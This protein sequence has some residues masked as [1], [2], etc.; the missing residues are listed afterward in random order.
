MQ[1]QPHE[2][3]L[4]PQMKQEQETSSTLELLTSF[5]HAGFVLIGTAFLLFEI[6]FVTLLANSFW[7]P[8]NLVPLGVPVIVLITAATHFVLRASEE[9]PLVRALSFIWKGRPPV[10]YRRWLK[11]DENGFTFGVKRIRWTVIESAELSFF[12]N[13]VF[14]SR[15]LCGEPCLINGKDHNPAEVILKLPFSAAGLNEQKRFFEALKANRPAVQL[16]SRL[17]KQIEQP[18]LKGIALVQAATVAFLFAALV[19]AGYSTFVYLETL[20]GYYQCL[21]DGRDRKSTALSNFERAEDLRLHPFPIS[22]V[23][24]KLTS[25]GGVSEVLQQARSEALWSLG[26]REES[27]AVAKEIAESSPKAFRSHLRLARLYCLLGKQD[28]AQDELKTAIEKRDEALLPR[29]Y[30]ISLLLERGR[31]HDAL[32]AFEKY[33]SKLDEEVFG[34]RPVWPPGGERFVTDVWYR[35]DLDFVFNNELK[36]AKAH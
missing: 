13:L 26:K 6:L 35:D 33:S 30:L 29:V 12:G 14:K 21:L 7:F 19:D 23:S 25:F 10:L 28:C 11:L 17:L 5:S 24:R 15:A 8:L 16:N 4:P 2:G 34:E 32:E 31:N 9:E 18:K 36:D 27:V 1:S 20:K 3:N 22:W